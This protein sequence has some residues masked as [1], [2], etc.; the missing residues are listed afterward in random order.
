MECETYIKLILTFLITAF[1]VASVPI[2]TTASERVINYEQTQTV[3]VDPANAVDNLSKQLTAKAEA[4]AGTRQGQCV[5]SVRQFL[6]VG[7]SEVQGWATNTKINSKVPEVGS[8]I[9]FWGSR[10]NKYGHVG[11]VLFTTADGYVYYYSPNSV[12]TWKQIMNGQGRASIQKTKIG[13]RT[14]KG[15]RNVPLVLG[16]I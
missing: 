14:I 2:D 1:V 16:P 7:R 10:W 5:V 8:I 6:G 3:Q 15:Y 11:T 9:I 13:N 4:L 12:G